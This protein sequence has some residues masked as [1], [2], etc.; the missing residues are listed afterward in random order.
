[1]DIH[2]CSSWL[3]DYIAPVIHHYAQPCAACHLLQLIARW[4]CCVTDLQHTVQMLRSIV[5][6]RGW[7][8]DDEV[9][10]Q[11]TALMFTAVKT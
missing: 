11:N 4:Q 1:M 9:H 10:L 2:N 7:I 5:Q 8:H 6:D 3:Y